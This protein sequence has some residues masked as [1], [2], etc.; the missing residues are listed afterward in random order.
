MCE[1]AE[2]AYKAATAKRA[3]ELELVAKIKEIVMARYKQ[4]AD[5][6]RARGMKSV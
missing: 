5:S 6:I 1:S 3:D 2:R 4:I